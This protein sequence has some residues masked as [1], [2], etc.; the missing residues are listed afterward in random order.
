ME[1]GGMNEGPDGR[2]DGRS[3]ERPKRRE[4]FETFPLQQRRGVKTFL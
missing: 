4:K 2:T 1:N 3:L